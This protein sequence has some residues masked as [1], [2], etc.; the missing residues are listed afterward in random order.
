[1][2]LAIKEALQKAGT[3]DSK[4]TVYAQPLVVQ[5]EQAA[6]GAKDDEPSD[7][8]VDTI[9]ELVKNQNEY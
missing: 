5:E 9:L 3:R 1:M 4:G 6:Y 7:Q 2:R 8:L